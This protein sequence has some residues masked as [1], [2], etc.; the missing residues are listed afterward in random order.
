MDREI[1]EGRYSRNL[2][3]MLKKTIFFFT[4]YIYIMAAAQE[5]FKLYNH[6]SSIASEEKLDVNDI[7]TKSKSKNFIRELEKSRTPGRFPK[8]ERELRALVDA[9]ENGEILDGDMQRIIA[10]LMAVVGHWSKRTDGSSEKMQRFRNQ[11]IGMILTVIKAINDKEDLQKKL[12]ISNKKLADQKPIE[13]GFCPQMD[14]SWH[15]SESKINATARQQAEQKAQEAQA[16]RQQAE[17]KAQQAQ[18]ARQQAEQRAWQAQAARQQAEQRAWQAQAE[19]AA[20]EQKAQ[21]AQAEKTAA[22]QKA[23]QAQAEKAAAEQKAQEA[24][25]EKAAAEQKAQQADDAHKTEAQIEKA[26][27]EKKLIEA[28]NKV[29]EADQRIQNALRNV[30]IANQKAFKASQEAENYLKEAEEALTEVDEANNRAARLEKETTE[31]KN[32]AA[33]LEEMANEL[34]A[35]SEQAVQDAEEREAARLKC[36]GEL[37]KVLAER[38]KMEE[39][40]NEAQQKLKDE[41]KNNLRELEEKHTAEIEQLATNIR[42]ISTPEVQEVKD[43]IEQ[44]NKKLKD[45]HMVRKNALEETY[46]KKFKDLNDERNKYRQTFTDQETRL[47]TLLVELTK[48]RAD[49]ESLQRD[50]D[51]MRKEYDEKKA[52]L[53]KRLSECEKKLREEEKALEKSPPESSE[54]IKRNLQTCKE[55]KEVLLKRIEALEIKK[56]AHEKKSKQKNPRDKQHAD[57]S[58]NELIANKEK[59]LK[60]C[61]D[62]NKQLMKENN[63][64]K[65]LQTDQKDAGQKLRECNTEKALMTQEYDKKKAELDAEK[66]DLEEKF[67]RCND[68]L[69]ACKTAKVALEEELRAKR[70][71]EQ[72][73]GDQSELNM[74]HA[75]IMLRRTE[76]KKCNEKTARLE[77]EKQTLQGKYKENE[78]ARTNLR[79]RKEEWEKRFNET[80]KSL[81]KCE[82]ERDK[83]KNEWGNVVD[84]NTALKKEHE[85]KDRTILEL[86]KEN[87]NLKNINSENAGILDFKNILR[88]AIPSNG[89][90]D[91]ERDEIVK[92]LNDNFINALS[93]YHAAR[94]EGSMPGTFGGKIKFTQPL[95]KYIMVL[96]IIALVLIF[97]CCAFKNI[98]DKYPNNYTC[99]VI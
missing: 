75:N 72:K 57:R 24:Q 83:S 87:E 34:S 51:N 23:Q 89:P 81:E 62:L 18:A 91:T 33:E 32:R 94:V 5:I 56:L 85:K 13:D 21:Q 70:K 49:N 35:I 54:D 3:C 53:E 63:Q 40:Y 71:V 4:E 42:G 39:E 28:E 67:N 93:K 9:V 55:E 96:I 2:I 17:Q 64:L 20:A 7:Y 45:E 60:K 44:A 46:D 76:L 98:P 31:A 69:R 10:L 80:Q 38:K 41:H 19:K 73:T 29:D 68:E 47:Q 58:R 99:N 95:I 65:K 37:T 84:R 30:D 48:S 36:E 78:Q 43:M 14:D 15:C 66:K 92:N 6:I 97:F 22:E 8:H 59:A 25:A 90:E 27:A 79:A 11:A 12:K 82:G 77:Q 86:E 74:M 52:S 26:E 61:L 88:N 50:L 16:A 1:Q